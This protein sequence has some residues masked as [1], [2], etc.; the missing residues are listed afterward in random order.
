MDI[1]A[2]E[3]FI[4]EAK[5]ACYVG[6]GGRL[7]SSR[8]GSHDIGWQRGD[9]RYLDSYYGGTN[10][11][12]QE[13]VW[14]R[15]EPVWAMNYFG[16]VTNP[17]LIDASRAGTVIKAALSALYRDEKRFLGGFRFEHRFGCY[18]DE[19]TGEV[20][21]FS[22]REVILVDGREAYALLYHGGLVTA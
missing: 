14:H 21:G 2:L 1:R 20:S 17:D 16:T 13:V 8:P 4:V 5:A 3:S 22:G 18:L 10:F 19:S 9:W 7:P 15:D 6:D 11:P 12:G